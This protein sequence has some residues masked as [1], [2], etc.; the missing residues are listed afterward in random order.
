MSIPLATT[1]VTIK[2]KRPQSTL[3]PDADG[4]DSDAPA[5]TE[6]ATNVRASITLP[7]G[8]RSKPGDEVDGYILRIDPVDVGLN[9]H[10]EVIDEQDG[11]EYTVVWAVASKPTAYGLQHIKAKL[12]L[13]RGI[14]SGG[15]SDAARD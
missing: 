1:T 9:Q 15:V 8:R 7:E 6:L 11:A 14:K 10:D 3:D 13:T 2:G 5:D 12:Q 4:Y